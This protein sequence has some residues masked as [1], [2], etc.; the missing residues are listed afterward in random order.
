MGR[1][2]EY[3]E[4]VVGTEESYFHMI[5]KELTA[6]RQKMA[7]MLTQAGMLP[8]IPDGSYFMIADASNLGE[9]LAIL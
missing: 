9:L 7:E 3:E 4:K 5:A 8:S 1:A 6:K 2:F